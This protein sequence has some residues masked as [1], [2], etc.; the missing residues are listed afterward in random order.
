MAVNLSPIKD[1]SGVSIGITAI[2]RDVT[3]RVRNTRLRTDQLRFEQLISNLSADFINLPAHLIDQ[4]MNRALQLIGQFIGV[5]RSIVLLL[6]SD[7][8]T[9]N[10]VGPAAAGRRYS[11]RSGEGPRRG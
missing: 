8:A 7:G 6:S 4:E 3:E 5:D 10:P 2:I 9:R 11:E 1:D